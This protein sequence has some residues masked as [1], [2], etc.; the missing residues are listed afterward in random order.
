MTARASAFIATIFLL[1]GCHGAIGDQQRESR[2]SCAVALV[3]DGEPISSFLA[4]PGPSFV[5]AYVRFDDDLPPDVIFGIDQEFLDGVTNPF[6]YK[7]GDWMS[8]IGIQ[9]SGAVW[10][11]HGTDETKNGTPSK[12]RTWKIFNLGRQLKPNTWYRLRIEADFDTRHFLKFTVEGPG[13]AKSFDLSE[14]MLDYPNYM[15]FSDR[16]M[17]FYVCA[18][19]GRSLMDP[20][21][22]DRGKPVVYFDD[23]SGGPIAENG[24]D[25][26]A[27]EDG[28]EE[29]Y[30]IGKQPVTAPVIDL[31]GY[32][33][34]R[35]YL[36][37]DEALFNQK[38]MPFARSGQAV[39][40]ADASID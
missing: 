9:R 38:M 13:L 37:R 3:Y 10:V 31:R 21:A 32:V 35:W 23:V 12:E 30:E 18:M 24:G 25:I 20:N 2:L 14:L 5:Q 11:A 22:T 39:G 26:V 15:P 17:S 1:T 16:A 6:H 34:G 28:F 8:F 29:S 33:Q 27:F 40:V 7:G 19:R 36:E 4:Q